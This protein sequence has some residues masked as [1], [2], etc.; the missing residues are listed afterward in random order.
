MLYP[1][2]GIVQKVDAFPA[3]W[4]PASSPFTRFPNCYLGKSVLLDKRDT[5]ES[6]FAEERYVV[7]LMDILGDGGIELQIPWYERSR[8]VFA[9][10]HHL[11]VQELRYRVLQ[12]AGGVVVNAVAVVVAG[13]AEQVEPPASPQ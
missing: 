5:M 3:D 4:I 1:E 9:Y 12:P 8:V 6:A 11:R 2:E 7:A 13:P 10:A